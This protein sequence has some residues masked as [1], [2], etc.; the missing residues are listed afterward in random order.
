MALGGRCW[1]SLPSLSPLSICPV[2]V[3]VPNNITLVGYFWFARRWSTPRWFHGPSPSCPSFA[4]LPWIVPLVWDTFSLNFTPAYSRH[5]LH[6]DSVLAHDKR[7]AHTG[8][9]EDQ[10]SCTRVRAN[11]GGSL[12]PKIRSHIDEYTMCKDRV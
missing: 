2:S 3:R 11:C 12:P 7:I 10:C 5:L 1:L 8:L 4:L 9:N 6:R